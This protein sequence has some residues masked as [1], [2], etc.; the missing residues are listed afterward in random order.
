MTSISIDLNKIPDS[1]RLSY[2]E[3]LLAYMGDFRLS[4]NL[5]FDESK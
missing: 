2:M 3:S 1:G 5:E 4:D